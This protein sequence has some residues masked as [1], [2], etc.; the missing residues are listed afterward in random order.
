MNVTTPTFVINFVYNG[1]A[2][3]F[4]P[5]EYQYF[6]DNPQE[7]FEL[8]IRQYSVATFWLATMKK[9]HR[10]AQQELSVYSG[11]LYHQL[12]I[13]GGYAAKYKG[14]R[15]TEESLRQAIWDDRTYRELMTT[16]SELEEIVDQLWGV[17]RTADRKLDAVK[18]I[19]ALTRSAQYSNRSSAAA[20]RAEMY[21]ETH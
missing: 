7:S 4:D 15:P 9:R 6:G 10:V 2:I 14:A 11:R 12:K 1:R 16:V 8:A 19:C 17:V 18:E 3:A 20:P 5:S 13:E 21:E